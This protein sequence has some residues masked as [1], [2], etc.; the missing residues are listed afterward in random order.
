MAEIDGRAYEVG[1]VTQ[2]L[3][4][5]NDGDDLAHA[6]LEYRR[7]MTSINEHVEEFGGTAAGELTLKFK[8]KGDA[9][10]VDVAI[11]SAKKL[12][13]HPSTEARYFVT[14]QGDGLTLQNPNRE[15]MFPGADLGRRRAGDPT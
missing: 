13:K 4:V 2:L 5:N 11:E 14:R 7:I 9:K 8:F 6:N 12:P 10:G 15:T 1:S 3:M